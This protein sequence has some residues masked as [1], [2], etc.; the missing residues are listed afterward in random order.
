MSSSDSIN[1]G[2]NSTICEF[3]DATVSSIASAHCMVI[4]T[5]TVVRFVP[6]VLLTSAGDTPLSYVLIPVNR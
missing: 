6:A 4:D 2:V 3:V 5:G 1:S